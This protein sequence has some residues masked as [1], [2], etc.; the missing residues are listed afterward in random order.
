MKKTYFYLPA[1]LVFLLFISCE[2]PFKEDT[3]KELVR[4][5]VHDYFGTD[6]MGKWTFFWDGKNEKGKYIGPGKYIY[7]LE[8]KRFSDQDFVVA[9]EGG[10]NESNDQRRFE[11]GFWHDYELGRAFPDP[12]KIR[13]GVNIPVLLSEPATVKL[14]IY[15]D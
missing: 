12:F 9:E 7:V 14:S 4:K 11:P 3:K 13:D 6:D 1:I 15:K 5:L 10:K 2:N 8:I